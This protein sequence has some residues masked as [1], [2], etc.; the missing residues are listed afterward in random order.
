MKARDLKQFKRTDSL[1][2][3]IFRVNQIINVLQDQEERIEALETERVVSTVFDSPE[4]I[5]AIVERARELMG[6]D[7]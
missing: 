5:A 6:Q 1:E 7:R 3:L 4:G 2:D